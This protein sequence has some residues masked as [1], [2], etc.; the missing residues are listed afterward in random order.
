MLRFIRTSALALVALLLVAGPALA[1]SVSPLRT[2]LRPT[3]PG[4]T[5][6]VTIS[7]TEAAPITLTVTAYEVTIA[8]DG[9][10]TTAPTQDLVV[11]PPQ[12]IVQPGAEQ[13]LQLRYVGP[14]DKAPTLYDVFI[15]QLPIQA[16]GG[17]QA[18]I[19]VAL[20]FHL[21][22]VMEPEQARPG[23]T[24][25]APRRADDGTRWLFEVTNAGDGF[26]RLNRGTWTGRVAGE[27]VPLS[28]EDLVIEGTSYI[29]PGTTRTVAIA[30]DRVAPDAAL[31]SVGFEPDA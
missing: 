24:A 3:G 13:A 5:D 26:A 9:A 20:D 7:N 12:A 23:L 18:A 17:D 25:G 15:E 4:A 6:R 2:V 28:A 19:K 27:A 21:G 10:M 31:S 1:Y 11:F 14:A 8:E 30:A 16:V 29:A 22:V